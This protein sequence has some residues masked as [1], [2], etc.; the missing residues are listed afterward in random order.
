MSIP[1]ITPLGDSGLLL[2]FDNPGEAAAAAGCLTRAKPDWLLDAVPAYAA[3]T[4]VYEPYQLNRLLRSGRLRL[5]AEREQEGL[6]Y[7]AA[8]A[9][10]RQVLGS[11]ILRSISEQKRVVEVPVVYGG[12]SGPDLDS[13]AARAGMRPEQFIEAHAEAVYTVAMIGFMPGFPYMTGLPERLAQPRR[14]TPRQRI[15]AGSVAVAGNQTGIYPFESPGGW[16]I[17]GRTSM[18]LFKFLADSPTRLQAGDT[19]R[20]VPVP[21]A[22]AGRDEVSGR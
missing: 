2:L 18:Q 1:Q 17:I 12:D 14:T 11:D 13:C 22:Q 5:P 15:P 16:Q 21:A 3:L 10:V 6:L 9:A 7:A 20:F 19:V 8:A 4:V